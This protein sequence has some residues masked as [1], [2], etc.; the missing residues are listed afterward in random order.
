MFVKR[1]LRCVETILMELLCVCLERSRRTCSSLDAVVSY[2]SAK[3]WTV[4]CPLSEDNRV[5]SGPA[6]RSVPLQCLKRTVCLSK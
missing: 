2:F 6:G 3:L 4:L 1:R 5:R